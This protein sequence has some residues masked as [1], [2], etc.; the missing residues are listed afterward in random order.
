MKCIFNGNLPPNKMFLSGFEL[1]Q[2]SLMSNQ[3]EIFLLRNNTM[4]IVEPDGNVS[5]LL[6]CLKLCGL[7]FCYT[8]YYGYE[9]LDF[10]AV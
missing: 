4:L 8:F 1:P 5:D 6:Y 10:Y 9:R 2:R 3:K 7:I